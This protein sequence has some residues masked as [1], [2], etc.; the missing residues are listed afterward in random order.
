MENLSLVFPRALQKPGYRARQTDS[1]PRF[2]DVE[3]LSHGMT[4]NP[5]RE[6]RPPFLSEKMVSGVSWLCHTAAVNL[7]RSVM[8]DYGILLPL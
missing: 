3:A 7:L 2:P 6:V 8:N 1:K 4:D 5:E